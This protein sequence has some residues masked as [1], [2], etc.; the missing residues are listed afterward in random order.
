MKDGGT[1]H[2]DDRDAVR[3]IT[4]DRPP[5]NALTLEMLQA[6]DNAIRDA[7]SI[8]VKA[9]VLT[10]AGEV[11]SAGIDTTMLEELGKSARQTL[12]PQLDR[13][14][15]T[16]ALCELPIVAAVNGAAAGVAAIVMALCDRRVAAMKRTKIGLPE[17]KVG[18]ALSSKVHGAMARVIGSRWAD[19]LCIEG[20]MLSAG[21]ALRIGLID[22]LVPGSQV[23]ERSLSWCQGLDE[24]PRETMLEARANARSDLHRLMRR[25]G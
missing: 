2:V 7:Q 3:I 24:L 10:G 5:V 1:V 9:V 12:G 18:M 25:D 22:E 6:L 21:D 13:I 11:F 23:I 16:T 19:R 8:T 20:L 4:L 15:E 17:V 14:L